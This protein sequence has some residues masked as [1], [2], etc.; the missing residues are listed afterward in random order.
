MTDET[1]AL[2]LRPGDVIVFSTTAALTHGELWAEQAR[3][4]EAFP[5]NPAFV[6]MQA[7]ALDTRFAPFTDEQVHALRNAVFGTL[8]DADNAELA[9]ILEELDNEVAR[10]AERAAE[11]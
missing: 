7:S 10:R 1:K 11:G 9:P 6:V 3:L 8:A 2:R 5:D 4:K